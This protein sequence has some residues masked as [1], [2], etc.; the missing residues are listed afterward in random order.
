MNTLRSELSLKLAGERTAL[1]WN[2]ERERMRLLVRWV[3]MA[4]AEPARCSL[5]SYN[6]RY[7]TGLSSHA[8]IRTEEKK[9]GAVEIVP[10]LKCIIL[11]KKS[12]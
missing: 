4:T 2:L 3:A 7:S 12:I 11:I 9:G 1:D 10:L 8:P 5:K 6:I